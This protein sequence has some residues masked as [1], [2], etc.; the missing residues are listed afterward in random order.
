M[1]DPV[2]SRYA[3]ALFG[4]AK[5]SGVLEA[6]RSDV[7][8]IAG[9]LREGG[10]LSA[11]FDERLPLETRR[12]RAA[13]A[14]GSLGALGALNPL[15]QDFV[16]LLF[17]KRRVEVLRHL[18]A[19]FHRRD[20]EER[21]AAEGVVESARPLDAAELGR[22]ATSLGPRLGKALVLQN[23]IVPGLIGGLR[24]V[25]ESKMIDASLAGRLEGLRRNLLAAPLPRLEG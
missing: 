2:T 13:A 18:G 21:G 16:Q 20:L 9:E 5:R 8:A 7:R 22:L 12:A 6:V 23:R 1:I 25:V 4:L 10:R 14:L 3:E 17:D 11:V 24:V 15:T 19:A